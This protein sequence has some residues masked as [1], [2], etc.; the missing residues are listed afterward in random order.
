MKRIVFILLLYLSG[1]QALKAQFVDSLGSVTGTF[2]D[3]ITRKAIPLATILLF[4]QTKLVDGTLTDSQGHFVFNNLPLGTYSLAF[5][6]VGYRPTQTNVWTIQ[7]Q[8]PTQNLGIIAVHQ[9]VTNLQAITVRGQKPLIEQRVDGITFNAESLPSIAGSDASDVLRKVPLLS[10]DATGGLSMRG[11]SNI[12]VFID[13]KPSDLYASSVA[14]ALK[15]ISGESIVKV[16]LITHPSARYDTEGTDG[17]VNIITRKNRDNATNGTIS[18]VLGNR[19]EILMGDIQSKYGKWLAKLDGYYQPYWNRNGSVLERET[20]PF[21]IIQKNESRQSGNY[22]YGG[23]SLLYSLDT[24]NTLTMGYRLR[25]SPYQTHLLSANYTIAN[26]QL[27]P[28]FQRRI[29]SPF[30]N[31]GSTF[32]AGYTR[33][34]ADKQNGSPK[35]EFSLLGMYYLFNGT[36]RYDMEQVA[37]TPYKENFYGKTLNHDLL[38]QADYTQLFT[39]KLKW[40]T[41]GKLTRK[42]LKSDSW[43]GI[44][45]FANQDFANDVIRSN[46][47]SYQSSIYALYANLSF[48]LKTWQLMAGLRYEKTDL[49]ASFKDNL[50]Q[51]PSFQNLA[52]N[53]LISRNLNQK[54]TL[55][56]GYTVKLVRPYFSY[57]N[58]T[59]NRSDSLNIQFG[60]P[61]LQPEIT[62]RYQLSYSRNGTRL[63]TDIALFYNHNQNSIETIR[64]AR[65]DSVFESTF[66]NIGRNKRLG[67]SVNLTWK[68][69]PKISLGG[70]LTTQYV[71][72]ESPIMQLTNSGLMRQFVL[73]YSH[74]LPKG[75]SIDFYGFFDANSIQLQ[76]YRSGWKYYSLTFSKKSADDRFNLSLRMDTPLSQYTFIDE[77]I[78]TNAFHQRQTTRYQNQ[79]LRLTGSFKLGRKQIKSPRVRQAENPD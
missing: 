31:N 26:E 65:P 74:K 37:Q 52:P 28:T 42:N 33:N 62:R 46:G 6:A 5:S 58:P 22:V 67:V 78:T 57:L 9:D 72:L 53:L 55:K 1:T 60:N 56:L 71:Q 44:Y 77:V 75:Y 3:S 23:A 38:I 2:A 13:G 66:Q 15:S 41:G 17:V 39:D 61:Y 51:L 20:G 19:S 30:S 76:G 8:H 70:T 35:R 59:V 48:Q 21:R 54:S 14:D 18:A 32:S 69:T 47:F 40:E 63:F 10:V 11:S 45:D 7:T 27:T 25:R 73:N 34:S 24:L 64:T 29:E 16:E 43:F 4:Q 49:A 50:L 12:R 36:N 68:P 79:N